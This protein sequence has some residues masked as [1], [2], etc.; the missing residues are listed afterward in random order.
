MDK[1]QIRTGEITLEGKNENEIKQ[2]LQKY[3]ERYIQ[4]LE[5]VDDIDLQIIY[6]HKYYLLEQAREFTSAKKYDFACVFFAT[7]FEHWVNDVIMTLSL[8]HLIEETVVNEI[9][10][11]TSIKG[12]FTWLMAVLNAPEIADYHAKTVQVVSEA[13]NSYVHYKY[14]PRSLGDLRMDEQRM[15]NLLK[16]A[17]EAVAYFENYSV[18][19]HIDV[20][21]EKLLPLMPKYLNVT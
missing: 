11:E 1:V 12:K 20:P 21:D 6:D 4:E 18:S 13:R 7:W 3:L 16:K 19:N 14:K 17:E 2:T 10:R 15:S 8:R 5:T 9:I